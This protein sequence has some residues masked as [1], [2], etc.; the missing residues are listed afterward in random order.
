MG[1]VARTFYDLNGDCDPLSNDTNGRRDNMIKL[2]LTTC[3]FGLLLSSAS[4]E[5]KTLEQLRGEANNIFG[6]EGLQKH[7][8]T[9]VVASGKNGRIGFFHALDPD[10][11]SKEPEHGT[12]KTTDTSQYAGYPK[13]S[14]YVKCN[15]HKVKGTQIDYKSADKYTGSD[16]F[17]VLVLFPNGFAWEVTYDVSVR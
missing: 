16:V 2:L 12:V 10:C 17:E 14:A 4:A 3:A 7:K 13:D 8:M 5:E 11:T 1:C 15:Q 6:H 9:R